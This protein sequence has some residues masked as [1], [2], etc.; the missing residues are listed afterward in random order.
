MKNLKGIFYA[1]ISSGTFG[2]IPLF[3]IPLM[4]SYNMEISSILFYRFVFSSLIIGA[5]CLMRK[6]SFKIPKN[7]LFSVIILGLLYA[8]TALCLIYS[9]QYIPSGV[10]TTIH[11]LYPISVSLLMVCFFKEKKSVLL[12]VA[13]ILSL[14][15]VGLLCWSSD[16][17][18]NM[19]GILI[20]SFTIFTYA[21]YIVGV[22]QTPAGKLNSE[23][24]TFYIL[25]LG[26]IVFFIFDITT[27]GIQPIPN[28]NAGWRLL[29]LAFLPTVIS[30]LTLILAI[31]Y[32]GSTVTSILGSMEP[33]V[34]VLI[35]ILYF[36]EEFSLNSF[37]GMIL[38]FV[39]VIM[40]ILSSRKSDTEKIPTT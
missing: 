2:L 14:I 27:T 29:L 23:V 33:L 24:L 17:I 5:I 7:T 26:A 8:A 30:D 21:L 12:F 19:K 20:V 18:L 39:S 22:N 11:F 9:Y 37:L 1:L 34:A 31:R 35:G 38:I 15:G 40:V 36:Q 4:T 13:A 25:F 16:S 28:L 10:A 6:E 32:S 3:S